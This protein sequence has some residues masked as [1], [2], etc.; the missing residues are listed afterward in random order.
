MGGRSLIRFLRSVLPDDLRRW[1]FDP[2]LAELTARAAARGPGHSPGPVRVLGLWLQCWAVGVRSVLRRAV[3]VLRRPQQSPQFS[4]PPQDSESVMQSILQDVRYSFRALRASGGFAAVAI[5]T[6]ALGIGVNTTIF[7]IVDLMMFRPI[8]AV[9]DSHQLAFVMAR[10]GDAPFL[11]NLSYPNYQDLRAADTGFSDLLAYT[12]RIVGLSTDGSVAERAFAQ[13][14]TANYFEL[15]GMTIRHGRNFTEDEGLVDVPAP[16]L[17]LAHDYW[18]RRF[19]GAADVV[20]TTVEVN[21]VAFTVIG[22]APDG[23]V[24]IESMLAVQFYVPIGALPALSPANVDMLTARGRSPF[25]V[26]GR[27]PDEVGRPQLQEAVEV[28]GAQLRADFPQA[29]ANQQLAI[30]DER[31]ARPDPSAGGMFSQ[32]AVIFG[33]LVGMVLLIACANVANLMLAR[34]TG[35]DAEVAVRAALGA[36]RWRIVRQI[37]IESVML[38]LG[39]AGL[40]ILLASWSTHTLRGVVAGWQIDAPVQLLVQTDLRAIVF[41]TTVAVLASVIAGLVPALQITRGDLT[42]GLRQGSRTVSAGGAR[43]RLRGVLVAAQ[44]AVS[45]VLIVATGLFL[46]SLEGVRE[47]G[48]GFETDDRLY[49]SF[50]PS[51]VG[52]S[53]ADGLALYEELLESANALPGVRIAGLANSTPF[54]SGTGFVGTLAESEVTGDPDPGAMSVSWQVSPGYLEANGTRLLRGRDVAPTDTL[55]TPLVAVINELMA[56]ELWPDTDPIGQRFVNPASGATYEVI[57]VAEQGK[58]MLIWESPTRAFYAP[59]AQSYANSPTLVLHAEGDPLALADPVRELLK[60][61]APTV[62]VYGVM[63]AEVN[64]RDGRGLMLIRLAAGLVA[65]FGF[66]GLALATI[67]L[68]GV[69]AYAVGQRLR[70][71]GVRI[72]LG[73]DTRS[74]LRLVVRH[75]LL[76]AGVGVVLGTLLAVGVGRLLSTM[77][78]GVSPTDPLTFGVSIATVLATA[79]I[80]SLVPAWRATR[81]DPVN[82][83]RQ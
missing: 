33:L 80:A 10:D 25:R 70:E 29:N 1:V 46:R 3:A 40:G 23:Y 74:V 50:D 21:G 65:A 48:L 16:V 67:G 2:S 66:L 35:R 52:Y 57:G 11:M 77:L 64:L 34:A 32:I 8:P 36:G 37:V 78:V 51:I 22:V 61:L 39:G 58:Y 12:W 7:G 43:Q 47:S 62:P 55:A 79:V 15:Q 54:G 14:V 71:F 42:M 38:G 60:R 69:V 20:G 26:L 24:G 72:A 5:L 44:V 9:E 68:Y 49:A 19:G 75:G 59:V 73:A 4:L 45:L 81:V 6:L 83:L 53:P 30:V 17:V 31:A 13:V 82:A 41:G 76:M 28:A 63:T 56:A 27:V 18:L